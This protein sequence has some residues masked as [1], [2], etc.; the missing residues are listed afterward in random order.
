MAKQPSIQ[1]QTTNIA[2]MQTDIGYIKKSLENIDSQ[3]KT[4]DSSFVKKEDFVPV[5]KDH[6]TRIRR[7]ETWGFGAVGAIALLEFLFKY[8]K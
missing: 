2:V 3:L 5:E 4:M 1:T 8:F 6:E 7:L